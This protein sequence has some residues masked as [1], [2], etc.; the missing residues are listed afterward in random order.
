EIAAALV[1]F[2]NGNQAAASVIIIGLLILGMLVVEIRQEKDAAA[3]TK[4]RY[5]YAGALLLITI[6]FG[7]AG[8]S[9]FMYQSF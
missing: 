8:Q 7:M 1:P 2:G 5:L 6:L 4:H 9:N 3:F